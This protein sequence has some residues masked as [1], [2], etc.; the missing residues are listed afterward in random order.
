[1]TDLFTLFN[2][3][4]HH[5]RHIVA[6]LSSLVLVIGIAYS[7]HIGNQLRFVDESD[8]V[9]LATNLIERQSFTLDGVH[10]TAYRPV[11]YP[12]VLALFVWAGLDVVQMRIFNFVL[13]AGCIP[14]LYSIV[15]RIYG[16]LA[17]VIASLFVSLYPVLFYTCGVLVPQALNTFLL[18]LTL[19]LL[20]T[21]EWQTHSK[22]LIAGIAWG[23]QILTSPSFIFVLVLFMA[24][25]IWTLRSARSLTLAV[26][27]LLGTVFVILP[28]TA[29]NYHVFGKFALISTNS[30]WNLLLGNNEL[31]GPT[32]GANIVPPDYEKLQKGLDEVQRDSLYSRMALDFIMNNK[33][34]SVKM[35]FLKFANYFI[36]TDELATS[37]ELGR[38]RWYVL[39]FTYGPLLLL[40]LVRLLMVRSFALQP[41]EML[42]LAIYVGSALFFSIYFT[43]IRFRVPYDLLLIGLDAIFLSFLIQRKRTLSTILR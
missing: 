2:F 42:M 6:V 31:T 33:M 43:R 32:T 16:N 28:W 24:W 41:P 13:L 9:K 14:L 8:Y 27:F 40:L 7:L 21:E 18:L 22:Y 35:Y 1:V 23:I 34:Q 36:S 3:A 25:P 12:A 15:R 4:E 19:R 38:F 20:L 17:G 26:V 37:S 29:R 39:Q 10:P 5:D 11:G 30:G